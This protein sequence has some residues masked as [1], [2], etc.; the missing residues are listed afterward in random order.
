MYKILKVTYKPFLLITEEITEASIPINQA[1]QSGTLCVVITI[2]NDHTVRIV[3]LRTNKKYYIKTS[4]THF[5]KTRLISIYERFYVFTTLI[6]F[7]FVL[8]FT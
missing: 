2:V 5:T 6:A 1:I 8:L 7:F 4:T 3:K